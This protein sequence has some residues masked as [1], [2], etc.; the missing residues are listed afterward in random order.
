MIQLLSFIRLNM[1]GSLSMSV[2]IEQ[3]RA[4]LQR[5]LDVIELRRTAINVAFQNSDDELYMAA[6]D[7]NDT[8]IVELFR[9]TS[10][11]AEHAITEMRWRLPLPRTSEELQSRD[12]VTS[13][14]QLDS[15]H[16]LARRLQANHLR[17]LTAEMEV[18]YAAW[19][20]D[21]TELLQRVAD[22]RSKISRATD[23]PK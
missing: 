1:M 5:C 7:A 14:M 11:E 21:T 18:G 4:Q 19:G 16:S 23:D 3:L 9:R 10:I 2:Y 15:D 6:V 12:R 13:A 17:G 20:V 8:R 22:L